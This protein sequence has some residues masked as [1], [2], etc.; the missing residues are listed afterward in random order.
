MTTFA[1]LLTDLRDLIREYEI[2]IENC[3]RGMEVLGPDLF[4]IE[5]ARI[6]LHE[7]RMIER[8]VSLITSRE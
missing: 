6:E 4:D 5:A 2:H 3:H 7:L 1:A 8:F